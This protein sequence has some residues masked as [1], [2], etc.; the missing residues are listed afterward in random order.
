M[1]KTQNYFTQSW[2]IILVLMVL[3]FAGSSPLLAAVEKSNAIDRIVAIVND[4]VITSVELE[5]ELNIIKQQLRQQQTQLPPDNILEKQVLDRLVVTRI[6]L[7][8]AERRLLKVDD[9]SLNAAIANI[10][11]QNGLDIIAF[12][13]ALEAN[14]LNYTDYRERVRNEMIISRLQQREVQRKIN[15][16]DQ[17][18][19]D[20]L[21]NQDLQDSSSEEYRLQHILLVVPEAAAAERIQSAKL[22]AQQLLEQLQ[23][24]ADFTQLAIAES[25]GQQALNGG[26]LGWRKLGEIPS[27]FSGLVRNMQVGELSDVIR[28]PSGFHII[29]LAEKRSSEPQYIVNQTLARHILIQTSDLVSGAEALERV[30]KL[31][32]RIDNGEDFAQIASANSDDKGSAADGGSLGWVNPGIMV[33]EFEDAMNGLQPGEVSEPV[34]TQFGWHVIKVEDRRQHDN[35]EELV[36]RQAREFIM[37]QKLGPA[38]E[39]W[40]RQIKDEAFVQLRL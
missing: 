11:S 33:K 38:L 22:K 6:Q 12:R 31:K 4:D 21:A 26:D 10:A 39:N 24:G 23:S 25:D 7:Q 9:E 36:K 34:K 5:A 28:S 19:D 3:L 35:T 32:Q 30:Q 2:Q 18:I 40:I 29:K 15:V 8:Q 14:G 20:F 37:Q 17:E 27:L 1:I 13:Q 16:T